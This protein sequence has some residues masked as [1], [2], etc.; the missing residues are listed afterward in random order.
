M[1]KSRI[2]PAPASA[3][4]G[5]TRASGWKRAR[6]IGLL[7][8]LVSVAIPFLVPHHRPMLPGTNQKGPWR[9]TGPDTVL[10][11]DDTAWDPVKGER[12]IRQEIFDDIL[13]TIRSAS[14]LVLADFFLWNEWQGDPPERHR[15]LASEL[16]SV[17][18]ER[19]MVPG[20]DI[21]VMTDP[22]NRL[23][24]SRTPRFKDLLRETGTPVLVADLALL[25]DSN[26]LW[27][28]PVNFYGPILDR[29]PPLRRWADRPRIP[30]PFES[31]GLRLSVR[32]AA[33]LLHFKA[34][35]RKVLIADTPEGKWRLVVGSLN[36]ADGSSAHGN[37][38]VRMEGPIAVDA[39]RSETALAVTSLTGP[40]APQGTMLRRA[41]AILDH[42][43][44]PPAPGGPAQEVPPPGT[45]RARWLTEVAIADSIEARLDSLG[46]G[47]TADLALFYLSD[48]GIVRHIRSAA[49]RGVRFRIIL[50]PN[51]DAF[52]RRKNGIPNRP[53]AA[54][55]MRAA[56][57]RGWDLTVRWADTHGEQFHHKAMLTTTVDGA[58][59]L[60]LGSANW[61]RR[62]LRNLNLEAN[63]EI[64]NESRIAA[65]WRTWFERAWTNDDGL[66]RTVPHGAFAEP[67]WTTAWKT[68]VYRVQEWSGLSTF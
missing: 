46:R 1:S 19:S 66:V 64:E 24:G 43:R 51:R 63:I 5:E 38:A 54:E 26:P 14:T 22:L 39:L 40:Y 10:L 61:T 65:Q 13:E 42:H 2:K 34:N 58:E 28:R 52:G 68:L 4:I 49:T 29:V 48:R 31:D 23:Y 6:R 18:D 50:D 60:N 56:A 57:R 21:L 41:R 45:P 27:S 9:P 7:M 62:N 67:A 53:V 8:A 33:R 47:D 16:A 55:L 12:V 3:L 25:P 37:I 59:S 17:V 11:L 32:E 35:H 36:P 15:A 44:P 20:L 30:N